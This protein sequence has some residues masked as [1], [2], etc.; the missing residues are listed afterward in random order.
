MCDVTHS[1]HSSLCVTYIWTH[2]RDVNLYV[3]RDSFTYVTW[4]K[5]GSSAWVVHCIDRHASCRTW[6]TYAYICMHYAMAYICI[7]MYALYRGIHMHTFM[8]Q[9]CIDRHASCRSY[10]HQ[11]LRVSYVTPTHESRLTYKGVISWILIHIHIHIHIHIRI[12]IRNAFIFK[13]IMHS[14]SNS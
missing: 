5:R 3:W 9:I 14:Y 10:V 8:A 4:C 2:V 12:H 1:H 11:H 13:F 6:H 7:H